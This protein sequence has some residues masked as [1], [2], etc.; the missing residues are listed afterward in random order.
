M[1]TEAIDD[2]ITQQLMAAVARGYTDLMTPKRLKFPNGFRYRYFGRL[3]PVRSARAYC[4]STTKNANGKYLSWVFAYNAV[5]DVI[6]FS[7]V[8]E[9]KKRKDAKTRALNMH[10]K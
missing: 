10:K 9:H 3:E 7:K 1:T 8:V 4:W 6:G 2:P 5:K